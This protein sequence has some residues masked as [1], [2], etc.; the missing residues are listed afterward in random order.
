M[1]YVLRQRLANKSSLDNLGRQFFLL[2]FGK[3]IAQ[4]FSVK[5]PKNLWP[6]W[7][8]IP[9]PSKGDLTIVYFQLKI[10]F[11]VVDLKI[12]IKSF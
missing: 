9:G 10:L 12:I 3:R 7:M 8:G 11:S 1:F 2:F 5:T 4:L 6:D